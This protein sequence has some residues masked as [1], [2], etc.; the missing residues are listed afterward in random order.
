MSITDDLEA[1][2]DIPNLAGIAKPEDVSSISTRGFSKDYINWARVME[3]VRQNANGWLPYFETNS[4]GGIEFKAPD[5]S[6]YILVGF[7]DMI[8]G[9]KLPPIP[10]GQD[11]GKSP[12]GRDLADASM[13]GVCKAAALQFGLAWSMWSKDDPMER[14]QPIEPLN[15]EDF[16]KEAKQCA[17]K[18]SLDELIATSVRQLGQLPESEKDRVRKELKQYMTKL[19]TVS[20]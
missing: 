7:Q 10:H 1:V 16:L 12:S 2:D 19:E 5:G 3:Y 9:V 15:I 6:H 14:E 17:D 4:E 13:R 11:L 8:N 18:E 20:N